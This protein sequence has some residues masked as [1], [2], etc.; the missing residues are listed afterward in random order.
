MKTGDESKHW[1][2]G[3]DSCPSCNRGPG[4]RETSVP[5]QAWAIVDRI[6]NIAN[7]ADIRATKVEQVQ[8][9]CDLVKKVEREALERAAATLEAKA[10][11]LE[12]S[13]INGWNNHHLDECYRE[14]AE[15]IRGMSGDTVS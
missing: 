9:I 14:A 1:C 12:R 13:Q 10:A 7:R 8:A 3:D 5:E 4:L 6:G 2:T 15:H 11:E